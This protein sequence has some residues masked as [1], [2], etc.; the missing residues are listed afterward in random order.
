MPANAAVD[1]VRDFLA[2]DSLGGLRLGKPTS[3]GTLTLVP[4][5][6]DGPAL[7]YDSFADALKRRLIKVT[8][9]RGHG[10]VSSLA[11][12]NKSKPA[13]LMVEGEIL[14]G[15]K[16]NRVLNTTILVPPKTRLTIPVACVEARRWRRSTSFARKADYMLSSKIRG[17]QRQSVTYAARAFGGFAAD[18]QAVWQ[19]VADDLQAHGVSSSTAAYSDIEKERGR[20]IEDT[21]RRLQ[22]TPGQAGVLALLGGAVWSLDVFDRPSTLLQMW[23]ALVGSYAADALVPGKANP[24]VDL[25]MA[26]LW[27]RNLGVGQ[28]TCHQAV[29][30]GETV[31]VSG[32]NGSVSAL[33]VDGV[34]VHLAACPPD[35]DPLTLAHDEALGYAG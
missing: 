7:D 17:M 3:S 15:L 28:A 14:V 32:T 23:Q 11:V 22:P 33:V 21:L 6:R 8:E 31:L 13:V 25:A 10:D 26:D 34:V 9:V 16:Q 35:R 18:Q 20:Q 30:R 5:F 12:V 2:P 19:G 24:S 27:I 4:I 1:A 29:G